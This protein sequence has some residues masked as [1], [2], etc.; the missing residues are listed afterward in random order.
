[1]IMNHRITITTMRHDTDITNPSG[2]R[3]AGRAM[4]F[5]AALL[6]IVACD[7]E[8]LEGPVRTQVSDGEMT[9]GAVS[10]VA[11]KGYVEGVT[12]NDTPYDRLHDGL[13]ED[14]RPLRSL[15]LSAWMEPESGES[16]E[17]F[18]NEEFSETGDGLWRRDPAAYWPLA[19]K[20]DFLAYSTTLAPSATALSW[21]ADR[22]T[23]GFVL[24]ADRRF[25]QDDILYGG[26]TA[27]TQ[28]GAAPTSLVLAHA[29]AWLQ[30][31]VRSSED[32]VVTLD[33]I[34]VTGLYT[35]GELVVRRDAGRD[36]GAAASW[37]F[38]RS[39]AAATVVDDVHGTLGT[40]LLTEPCR[41]DMLV[42]QQPM[43]AFRVRY[44]LPGVSIRLSYLF[45]MPEATWWLMGRK[46]VYDITVSPREVTVTPT[47]TEWNEER[48][49]L[50]NNWLK[51]TGASVDE[52][53]E[54]FDLSEDSRIT[55]RV[56]A[57]EDYAPLVYSRGTY[58]SEV[59]YTCG[60]YVVTVKALG[61]GGYK[62]SYH[63]DWRKE[64]LTLEALSDGYLTFKDN[65]FKDNSWTGH[66]DFVTIEYSLNGGPWTGVTASAAGTKITD[67]A[68]GDMVRLRGENDILGYNRWTTERDLVYNSIGSSE[69][70]MFNAMGCA[71]SLLWGDDYMTEHA[72]EYGAI[73]GLF[74]GATGLVDAS[75]LV[76]P[77]GNRDSR[78]GSWGNARLMALFSGCTSLVA[79]P[80]LPCM[81]MNASG[82]AYM[83][84]GCT[85]LEKAPELPATDLHL[86]N[87]CY[88]YMFAECTA[89]REVPA[90]P[91]TTLAAWSYCHM[92]SGCTALTACPDISAVTAFTGAGSM[93]AMFLGCTA[94]TD[95]PAR[96]NAPALLQQSYE[97][98]F[99]DCTALVRAPEIEAVTATGSSGMHSM[100]YGCTSLIT[101]PTELKITDY[102]QNTC[103]NMF[104]GCT[105]MTYTPAITVETVASGSFN[106]TFAR[107]ARL[108]TIDIA[109]H[110]TALAYK[111]CAGMFYDCDALSSAMPM[112]VASLAQSSC[113]SMYDNCDNLASAPITFTATDFSGQACCRYMFVNCK[114]LPAAVPMTVGATG[115]GCFHEMYRGCTSLATC[116]DVHLEATVL[117]QNSCYNMFYNC[118][119]MTTAMDEI[120]AR[121]Y[122]SNSCFGMF[123]NCSSLT[124]M[125]AME[126]AET[127]NSCC[128]RMFSWNVL[129]TENRAVF[130][131]PSIAQ[132]AFAYMFE[133]CHALENA[134]DFAATSIGASGCYY[135]Y[136][137]CHALANAPALPM[138]TLGQSCYSY[139]FRYCY[140]LEAAPQLPATVAAPF[141]YDGMFYGSGLRH[142]PSALPLQ[143]LADGCCRNMF[144]ACSRMEDCFTDIPATVAAPACYCLMFKDCKA[145]TAGPEIHLSTLA[146]PYFQ[147]G[148]WQGCCEQMFFGCDVMVTGPTDFGTATPTR[149]CFRNM[150]GGCRAL[151]TAPASMSADPM[152]EGCYYQMFNNCTSLATPP[153]LP[154]TELAPSCYEGMFR[155]NYGADAMTA[156]PVLPAAVL[157][158]RCY[159]GMFIGNRNLSSVTMLATDVSSAGALSDWLR[160]VSGSGTLYKA[161]GT[162]LPAGYSGV[163][164]GWSTVDL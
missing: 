78:A 156:A 29:Q 59:E 162:T 43:R 62:I 103:W 15:R 66:S 3:F 36:A 131:A 99:A 93:A 32:G 134:P 151:V 50:D 86:Q 26:L 144:Q 69:G 142:G 5:L 82:Y 77:T 51:G 87:S 159:A 70:C 79:A 88:E 147:S 110:A 92:F 121:T 40:E 125:P 35:D 149:Y 57:T 114:L 84:Y 164:S 137:Q 14:Q 115:A 20:L 130:S 52:Y 98:M 117:A 24:Y 89:L 120:E 140:A 31:N 143:T 105:A 96:L 63:K 158:Q 85:S 27:R 22:T 119:A 7:V 135:M 23:D 139:M 25:T 83:F 138:T 65:N 95:A 42:P 148:G 146:D 94:L 46:Y 45:E 71:A 153:A 100:F 19:S 33:A 48:Q 81:H 39:T 74:K 157:A 133:D 124:R 112:E 163:P 111:S 12:L 16:K 108:S 55:W 123:R 73:P 44:R 102:A 56:D 58:G 2:R 28:R 75:Q 47:V 97:E 136:F 116:E 90:L 30:F 154:A 60:D 91:A 160:S 106:A 101:P 67:V 109:W 8:P 61:D 104:Y 53:G 10:R 113:E 64:P 150:F 107:C 145:L 76:V 80:E 13:P 34:E 128:S 129:I 54:D 126:V 6:A 132:S 1:M 118:S 122:G 11:T 152:A 38:A 161:A 68:E 127:A 72:V 17:Y 18:R 4:A 9:F 155:M 37:D 49:V 21:D 141:C 41:F